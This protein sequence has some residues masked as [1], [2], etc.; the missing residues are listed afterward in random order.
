LPRR[1]TR[2]GF[3]IRKADIWPLDRC[4]AASRPAFCESARTSEISD[5]GLLPPLFFVQIDGNHRQPDES[6]VR[7]RRRLNPADDPRAPNRL[8]EKEVYG[9]DSRPARVN[10]L[11]LMLSELSVGTSILGGQAEHPRSV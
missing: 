2:A 4:S 9:K 6:S 5:S 8:S 3:G 10:M 1:P 7:N 11:P